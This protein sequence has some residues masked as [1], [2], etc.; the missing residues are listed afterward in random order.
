MR[1]RRTLRAAR[2]YST[3]W[4]RAASIRRICSVN[5]NGAI[6]H[7]QY[8]VNVDFS[9]AGQS[10]G[11]EVNTAVVTALTTAQS[12]EVGAGQAVALTLQLSKAVAVDTSGGAPTVLLDTG[13]T[14]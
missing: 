4:S 12:G 5:L 3:T 2:L 6:I 13:A 11:L 14:A 9:A 7:D 1:L 10:L 8:N